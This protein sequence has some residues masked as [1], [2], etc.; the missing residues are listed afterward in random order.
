VKVIAVI[1]VIIAVYA[2]SAHAA[3]Q[4]HLNLP[5]VPHYELTT[6]LIVIPLNQPHYDHNL[7]YYRANEYGTDLVPF[8]VKV[9]PTESTAQSE[10]P[11]KA[12]EEQDRRLSD[13]TGDLAF[14][15]KYLFCA[16]SVAGSLHWCAR[17]RRVS[18]NARGARRD[19]SRYRLGE[20]N[21]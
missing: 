12:K 7:Q 8:V 10:Q 18:S 11:E 21:G 1:S 14:Y 19:Q 2:A 6:P 5:R 15:T 3:R 13:F 17:V 16:D 20:S 9:I 4:T